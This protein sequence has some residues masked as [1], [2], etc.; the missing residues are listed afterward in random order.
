MHILW[1]KKIKPL[2]GANFGIWRSDFLKIGGFDESFETYGGEEVD[3]EKRLLKEKI[4]ERKS[5][6]G[7]GY[8]F[9]FY[10]PKRSKRKIFVLNS[11]KAV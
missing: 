6:L 9:H 8:V 4:T 7:R 11:I 2:S 5:L 10:H 1:S 3:F